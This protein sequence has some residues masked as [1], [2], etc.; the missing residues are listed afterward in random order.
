M[1]SKVTGGNRD[2]DRCRKLVHVGAGE[3]DEVGFR[4]C[5]GLWLPCKL[6]KVGNNLSRDKVENTN[7]AHLGWAVG[8]ILVGNFGKSLF[9]SLL[10]FGFLCFGGKLKK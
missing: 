6:Q 7:W 10:S 9:V 4:R 1:A 2:G 8:L 3:V 5:L